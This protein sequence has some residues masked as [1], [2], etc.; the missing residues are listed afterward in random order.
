VPL[1]EEEVALIRSIV[2]NPDDDAPRLVYADWLD[3]HEQA[4]RAQ[5]IRLQC[6]IET[7]RVE[8]QSL[9]DRHHREWGQ[10]LSDNG[11]NH[12][13]FHRGFPEEISITLRDF[14]ETHADLNAIT[15]LRHL[16]FTGAND[17]ELA[18]LATLPVMS[19]VRVLELGRP[20]AHADMAAAAYGPDG[21]RA[22]S[23]S[24]YLSGLRKFSLHSHQVGMEGAQLIAAAPTFS[25]LTH[26]ALT[27]PHLFECATDVLLRLIASPILKNLVELRWGRDEISHALAVSRQFG[28]P[29]SLPPHG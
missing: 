20:A 2:A 25:N 3:E 19:Q 5:F 24:N 17:D 29:P 11:A 10:E 1:T 28:V 8:E 21:I 13:V 9:L 18:T 16:Q 14:L 27:D 6:Q 26:L 4:D 12:W 15:P 7:L 22:L 23:E